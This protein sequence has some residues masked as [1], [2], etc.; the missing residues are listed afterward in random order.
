MQNIYAEYLCRI[1]MQN[2]YAEYLCRIFMQ[3]I[4][5]EY[6]TNNKYPIMQS[7]LINPILNNPVLL[8]QLHKNLF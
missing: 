2:I 5:A 4:Y 7:F 8:T 3:N 6:F 1:F